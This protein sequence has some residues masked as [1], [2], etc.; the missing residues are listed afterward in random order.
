LPKPSNNKILAVSVFNGKPLEYK[1]KG[2]NV[3][4]QLPENPPNIVSSI[5][6][7]EL[8]KSVSGISTI[9][10]PDNKTIGPDPSLLTLINPASDQY[11]QGNQKILVN[12][13]KGSL[14]HNDG[15]WLGFEANDFEFVIDLKIKRPIKSINVGFLQKQDSR[16]FLPESVSFLHSEDGKMF[17]LIKTIGSGK[18]SR[19]RLVKRDDIYI[20]PE[21]ITTRYLKISAKNPRLCPSWHKEAGKKAWIFVDEITID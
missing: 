6:V 18:T 8:K 14:I 10:V 21:D 17:K 19:D 7:F 4:I 3:I 15:Q 5:L 20:N 16:I 12:N 9:N 2:E 1:T 11:G 13:K